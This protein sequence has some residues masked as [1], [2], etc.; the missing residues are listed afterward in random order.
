MGP[1]QSDP[2][3]GRDVGGFS[4]APAM[5]IRHYLGNVELKPGVRLPHHTNLLNRAVTIDLICETVQPMCWRAEVKVFGHSIIQTET[6]SNDDA[7]G[8]A[9]EQAF[10]EKFVGLLKD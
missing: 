1:N 7:A 3:S 6:F 8:R 2:T 9:A 5:E 10:V 4:Y